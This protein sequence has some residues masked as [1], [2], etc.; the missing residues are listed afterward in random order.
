[1]ILMRIIELV[2]RD[3]ARFAA[4]AGG[5]LLWCRAFALF[6]IVFAAAE[7]H[8]TEDVHVPS[9]QSVVLTEVLLD[10]QPGE[11][12]ARFRF[13]AP[14]IAREGGTV[15]AATAMADMDHLC[16][17]LALPYL[18]EFALDVGRIVISL[19]DRPT[20]FGTSEPDATQFFEEY[21]AGDGQCDLAG[22]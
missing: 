10:D 12:W 20:E 1:M 9:G 17:Y 11:T 4:P 3:C 21:V 6:F 19:S 16:S 5:A 7:V 14:E 8:A 2:R 13:V 15:F 18:D 22:Y